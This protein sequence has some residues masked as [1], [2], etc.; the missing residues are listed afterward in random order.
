[1]DETTKWFQCGCIGLLKHYLYLMCV[2]YLFNRMMV[3]KKKKK[4]HSSRAGLEPAT[5]ELEVQ[6]ANPLRHRD[7]RLFGR[8][9]TFY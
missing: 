7:A 8:K 6:C 3:K 1:M 5:F 9:F 2:R 4:K